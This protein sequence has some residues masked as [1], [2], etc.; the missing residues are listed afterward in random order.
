METR[1]VSI[2]VLLALLGT[3]PSYAHIGLIG[4][5]P[6]LPATAPVKRVHEVVNSNGTVSEGYDTNG[7]GLMDIEAVSHIL[8][9]KIDR[10]RGEVHI[11]HHKYP[12]MYI[13]DID[14]DHEPDRS[15]VDRGASGSCSDLHL[16]Q[17]DLHGDQR[18][19]HPSGD[20]RL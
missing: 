9:T 20:G 16:Y 6:E 11:D 7:D 17:E 4:R 2:G 19:P 8:Q 15:Y 14:Q 12:F 3:T 18:E 13:I 10:E 1:K 5:C